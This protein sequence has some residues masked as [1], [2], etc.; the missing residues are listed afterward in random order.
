MQ[1]C[2]EHDNLRITKSN[3]VILPSPRNVVKFS[4]CMLSSKIVVFI[5]LKL[6]LNSAGL[7]T[8]YIWV[9]NAL[10]KDNLMYLSKFW[11]LWFKMLDM[12]KNVVSSQFLTILHPLF[13][14]MQI[15]F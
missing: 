5:V 10:S 4:F 13:C 3:D 9:S 6:G 15:N 14:K 1:V 2:G 12:K 7:C 8:R 11:F